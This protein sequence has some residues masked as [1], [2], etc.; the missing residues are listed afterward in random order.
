M[1]QHQLRHFRNGKFPLR[2]FIKNILINQF[3]NYF[4]TQFQK[5]SHIIFISF[6]QVTYFETIQCFTIKDT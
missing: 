5:N 3:N 6:K 4:I 2:Y 1:I